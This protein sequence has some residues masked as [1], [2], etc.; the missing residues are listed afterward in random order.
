MGTIQIPDPLFKIDCWSAYGDAPEWYTTITVSAT[1]GGVEI[2]RRE[3][4]PDD[5]KIKYAYDEDAATDA[6]TR[7]IADKLRSLLGYEA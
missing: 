5:P 4:S 1:F 2:V 6:L 3:F 7:E